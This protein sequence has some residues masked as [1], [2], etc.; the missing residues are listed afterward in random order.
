M[1]GCGYLPFMS[2]GGGMLGMIASLMFIALL[3]YLAV[4]LF[5]S[6]T[7]TDSRTADR[8]DSLEILK[9]RLAKGEISTE[10]FNTLRNV[11]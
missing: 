8:R 7:S 11:L 2:F 4:K 3:T 5:R 1:W 6:L 9:I 10:E